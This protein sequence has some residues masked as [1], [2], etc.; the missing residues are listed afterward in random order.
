LTDNI[1]ISLY[2]REMPHDHDCVIIDIA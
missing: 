1:V 2:G